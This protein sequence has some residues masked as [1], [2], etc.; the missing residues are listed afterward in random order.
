M[1]EVR[2]TRLPSPKNGSQTRAKT[3]H[4]YSARYMAMPNPTNASAATGR[5]YGQFEGL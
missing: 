1:L 2:I 4:W 5:R 3:S